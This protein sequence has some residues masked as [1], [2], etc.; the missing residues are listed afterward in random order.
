MEKGGRDGKQSRPKKSS[1]E[2]GRGGRNQQK[3][4]RGGAEKA[5]YAPKPAARE[6]QTEDPLL[7]EQLSN[8]PVQL[9]NDLAYWQT[10]VSV[11]SH[12]T[13]YSGS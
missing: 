13:N 7:S 9:Q 11:P 12:L 10:R 4:A 6:E 5:Q 8:D 1:E 3:S 2:N